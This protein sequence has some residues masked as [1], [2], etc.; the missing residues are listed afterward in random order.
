MIENPLAVGC[1]LDEV[2]GVDK[3]ASP[4]TCAHCGRAGD[5]ATLVTIT[6]WTGAVL[7]CPACETVLLRI[8]RIPEVIYLDPH[9]ITYLHLFVASPDSRPGD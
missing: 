1:L 4:T 3:T 2:F 6:Q 8:G 9:T 7:R 5:L